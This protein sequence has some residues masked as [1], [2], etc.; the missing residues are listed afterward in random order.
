MAVLMP[1]QDLPHDSRGRLLARGLFCVGKNAQEDRLIYDRRPENGTMPRLRWAELPSGACF[2]RMLLRPNQYLRGSGDDLRNYYYSLKLPENWIKFNS[3]GR[4]VCA[5]VLREHGRDPQV[6]HRLCFR[7]LG[8]GDRNGCCIA[9]ATHEAVLKQHGVLQEANKLVYGQHVPVGDRWEGVYLDDLLIAQKVSMPYNIPL[10]GSFTPP[11]AQVDD[12]DMVQVARAERAYEEANLQRAVHKAFRAESSFRAWGAEVE[13]IKGTVGAPKDMRKQLWTLIEKIVAGGYVCQDVLRK[14]VGYLAF[15]FQYRRELYALLHHTYK[16]I[17]RMAKSRWVRMPGYIQDELRSCALHLPFA[18][19]SMRRQL[20]GSI[21]ATDATPTGGGAVLAK[22][23]SE[24]AAEL[25]RQSEIRGQAVRLDH[26]S[27]LCLDAEVP[28]EPSKFASVVAQCVHWHVCSS[29][30]FRQTSH[31][32]LQEARAL[33]RELI[34]MAGNPAWRNHIVICLNDSRVVV[35]CMSKGRSSSFKLNGVMRSLVPH[36]ILSGLGFGLI[37]I[38]TGANIA[39]H[40]SRFTPLPAPL[41]APRWLQKFGVAERGR[42]TGVEIFSRNGG[43]TAACRLKGFRMLSVVDLRA[44]HNVWTRE[45]ETLFSEEHVDWVWFAPPRDSFSPHSR[46]YRGVRLRSKDAPEGRDTHFKVRKGNALWMRTL[47]LAHLVLG[48]GG[49]VFIEHP[50]DSW[51]WHLPETRRFAQMWRLQTIRL[52]LDMFRDA[53]SGGRPVPQFVK[54]LT[55][56]SWLELL[57]RRGPG[58][59]GNTSS[60]TVRRVACGA[61]YPN[62]FFVK[63]WRMRLGTGKKA[64]RLRDAALTAEYRRGLRQAAGWILEVAARLG[65]PVSRRSSSRKLDAALEAAV[66]WSFQNGEKLYRATLGV[67]GVQRLFQVSGPL[68]RQT[69]GSI[70]AWRTLQPVQSRVPVTYTVLTALLVVLMSRSV[71]ESGRGREQWLC[72]MLASWLC[73]EALLRPGEAHELRVEDILLPDVSVGLQGDEG[74][75]IS[76]RRP[77]TRRVWRSQ[78]VLVKDEMLIRWTAWWIKDARPHRRLFRVGRRVWAQQVA[79]GFRGLA[80]EDRGYTLSSF[81]G[82]GATNLFRRTMNLAQLQY[83]GRW[84]RQERLKAYLQEAFS[85][86]VAASASSMARERIALVNQEWPLLSCPPPVARD[87]YLR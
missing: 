77:K 58:R 24:L 4:R 51:A 43:I 26:D 76:I 21:L 5:E 44:G 48:D 69:W 3:V 74:M 87:Q 34:R 12:E 33:R 72:S 1:E 60:L 37:W 68:L 78:F 65:K 36:L 54:I 46:D 80:L 63:S 49:Q 13:G 35:G 61:A 30:S 40:P 62:N 53:D 15:C 71:R 47:S 64:P 29:Y 86:Q 59:L 11:A 7:V 52:N 25:W 20:A 85:V 66:D 16:Y 57:E 8:M 22:V 10:D 84:A 79:E 56:G 6:A 81:R 73:F 67:L 17:D 2:T 19:C 41:K 23:P 38:E 50:A 27:D 32:N 82:G 42:T 83:H 55:N 45:V 75:V 18:Y 28:A 70:R 39:D 31:I 9:Q 14:I